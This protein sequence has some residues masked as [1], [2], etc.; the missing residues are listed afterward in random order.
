MG[1]SFFFSQRPQVRRFLLIQLVGALFWLSGV[2]LDMSASAALL[3]A[4][5]WSVTA[6]LR[7]QAGRWW[8]VIHALFA[9][10]VFFA[11][12]LDLAPGWYLLAF[13]ISWLVF[14][15]V[16]SSGVPLYLSN[17]QALTWLSEQLPHGASFMDVGA[18]TGTVLAWLA[19]TRPDLSLSGIEHAWLPWLI[20]KLRLSA[21]V[22]WQRG[23]YRRVS[24]AGVDVLYAFLSPVPMLELWQKARQE[25]RAGSWFISNTFEVPGE[26]P[27]E[28]IELNDWKHGR[29]LLWRM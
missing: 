11:S 15:H 23:D 2:L 25:M 13:G 12:Q 14:G 20:G 21:S 6:S 26:E 10:L 16:A 28:I 4:I 7:W 29:L 5:L 9:P 17:R 19:R 8:L 27:D 22:D 24:F 18:G 1:Q 3:P